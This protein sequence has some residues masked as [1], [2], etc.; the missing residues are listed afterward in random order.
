MNLPFAK[1]DCDGCF[2]HAKRLQQ[3]FVALERRIKAAPTWGVYSGTLG[4]LNNMLVALPLVQ[5]RPL[6]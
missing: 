3:Q 4:E 6:S 1:V 5:A 2:T